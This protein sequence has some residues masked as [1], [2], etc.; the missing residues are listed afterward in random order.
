MKSTFGL[1]LCILVSF[2]LAAQRAA[3]FSVTHFTSDNG[4]TQNSIKDADIDKNGFLW[5]ATESGL[6]RFDGQ[7]FKLYDRSSYPVLESNRLIAIKLKKDGLVYFVDENEVAYAFDREG[8]I[9]R[10]A[11]GERQRGMSPDY[12]RL[13]P[14]NADSTQNR[15][16]EEKKTHW[17]LFRL[18]KVSYLSGKKILWERDLSDVTSN[19]FKTNGYLN[20]KLYYLNNRFKLKSIDKNGN[21]EEVLLKGIDPTL[22]INPLFPYNYSFFQQGETLHL[23]FGRGIYQLHDVGDHTLSAELLLEVDVPGVCTYHNYPALNLQV[24]GSWT[25]GLYLFRRKQFKTLRHTNGFGNFYAQAVY[26]DSGILTT[27]GVIYPSSSRFNFPFGIREKYR[28]MLHDYKGHYWL[29]RELNGKEAPYYLTELDQQLNT[30]K[31]IRTEAAI[32]SLSQTPDSTIWVVPFLGNHLGK[33]TEDSVQWLAK[34][35]PFRSILMTL[36]ESNEVLWVAGINTLFKLN[37]RTGKEEHYKSL[38]RY[39]VETL[40]LDSNKVLWIGTTG[41]GFFALKQNKIYRFPLDTRNNLSNVHTFMEDKGGFMWMSTNNGLFR[42]KKSDLGN[43]MDKKT[44]TVYYQYFTK[45]S[46]FNTNEFNGSCYPSGIIMKDGKFSLPSMD[47]LVQ[48]YPDSIRTLLP[49]A[50][51]FIDKILV[52]GKEQKKSLYLRLAPSFQYLE[53]QVTSPYF[54]YAANQLI[55]YKV[56]GWDREWHPLKNNTLLLNSLPQGKYDVQFR[57]QAGFG[58]D[59]FITA[60]IPFTVLPF[61]YQTWYFKLA[62]LALA[63]IIVLAIVRIR[64]AN[65]V[66]RNKALELKV[67]QRT[68]HLQNANRLKEKMLMMVG[69]DLQS[70]LYFLGYLSQTNYESVQRDDKAKTEEMSLA[71]KN[72]SGKIYTFVEEFHL[73]ARIQDEEYSLRKEVFA[74]QSLLTE[75]ADFS[76]ELL[77]QFNNVMHL[78][79]DRDY[80]VYTNR[81]LL[82]AVLRN[83]IDNA[84]KHTRNGTITVACT[85]DRGMC[86]ITVTDTGNGIA[87]VELDK[88]RQLIAESTNRQ[89]APNHNNRLGFQ[90]IIDFTTRLE[91]ILSIESEQG[92][93]TQVKVAG[94][95]IHMERTLVPQ[96]G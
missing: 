37:I 73:W 77:Q 23:L 66:K 11:R 8:K 76:R 24:V 89:A 57:K 42:C 32:A 69:H 13:D 20:G 96:P 65:L 48:F 52:D 70:P 41:N 49:T 38:E 46:G 27:R 91:L 7:Q 63:L 53:I 36:P 55:E 35:W 22:R 74:L 26:Q 75:L 34:E 45:E 43:F 90:F 80:Q 51:I 94:L 1:L 59:N 21:I 79:T 44:T 64:Y 17:F 56:K 19:A 25:H 5:I 83:L 47:G 2:S 81:D 95:A 58:K 86:A 71:I 4:L 67:S 15:T 9:V 3:D 92:K 82:K 50:K 60:T 18:K 31:L 10:I 30:V 14:E 68:L 54:G 16:E 28:G 61:F 93:G 40:Y 72:T 29:N 62:V 84:N 6:L 33:V 39:T 88:I 78:Q 87:A 12:Y 85:T